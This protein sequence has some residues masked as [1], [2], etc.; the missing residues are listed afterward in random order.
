MAQTYNGNKIASEFETEF[1]TTNVINMH[2]ST[3]FPISIVALFSCPLAYAYANPEPCSGVCINAHDPTIIRR[4]SDGTYF[5]LSTGGKV[6][7]HSAPAL[8]GPWTYKCAM[9]PSGSSI[10]LEGN[11]DLWAPDVAKVGNEY[12]VY[13][14]VSAFG[15]QNSAIGLATSAT[16]DCGSFKDLGSTGVESRTGDPYNAI[17]G[18]LLRDGNAWQFS[19]G[20]FWSGLYQ[21]NMADPPVKSSGSDR[22]LATA[23]STTFFFSAG[24][25]CGYDASRPAP[26]EEYKIKVCRSNS[27]TGGF[28]DADGTSCTEG[29]GTVVL[30][31]HNNVYGPGGQG[32][33]NDPTEGWVLYYHYV[34]TS[35]GFGDGQKQ[36]GWNKIAWNN[37]WP[38]V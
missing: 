9:L 3:I 24:K 26:N 33:Y 7:I 20:S 27:A 21:T 6:A 31:S 15:G 23:T 38:T 22:Q 5:R 17:D 28:V 10:Q 8:S 2:L 34:D 18:N 35:I 19:F 1:V 36:F 16:M 25:C 30:E 13:Y 37:G 29:G 4:D 32:V 11:Q 12:Y 14:T